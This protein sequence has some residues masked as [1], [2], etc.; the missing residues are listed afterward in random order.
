MGP[1]GMFLLLGIVTLI[2]AIFVAVFIKETKGLSDKQKKQLFTP[3]DLL[4][5]DKQ[6]DQIK[7]ASIKTNESNPSTPKKEN[8]FEKTGNTA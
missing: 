5:L 8:L 4:H 1:E 3:K 6:R 2:G 7:L